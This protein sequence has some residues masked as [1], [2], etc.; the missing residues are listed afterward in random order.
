[1][2]DNT[3]SR[4][5]HYY[6]EGKISE[7]TQPRELYERVMSDKQ[8][9]NL[10]SNT[11][12]ML[13]HVNYPIIAKKYLAQIYNIKPEYAKGVYDLTTFKFEKSEGRFEFAEIEEMSRDAMTWHK[14]KKFQPDQGNRLVGFAPSQPFYHV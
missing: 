14:E 6:H 8:R 5:S 7:Y 12:K 9:A 11:A 10:H 1:M 2:S 13:G 3:V 4:K